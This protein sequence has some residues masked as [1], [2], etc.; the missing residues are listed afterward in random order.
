MPTVDAVA[1]ALFQYTLEKGTLPGAEAE[2]AAA[3]LEFNDELA[4]YRL[5]R[6]RAGTFLTAATSGVTGLLNDET[7]LAAFVK[8]NASAPAGN[9]A[10]PEPTKAEIEAAK[11]ELGTIE[12]YLASV[13]PALDA[14]VTQTDGLATVVGPPTGTAE[15][16][17]KRPETLER[18]AIRLV[19]KM[20]GRKV[21]PGKMVTSLLNEG[22]NVDAFD[23][24]ANQTAKE[25]GSL[26]LPV[27]TLREKLSG[28]KDPVITFAI[29]GSNL[30]GLRQIS[31]GLPSTVLEKMQPGE[32]SDPELATAVS[33]KS[34]IVRARV[35][36]TTAVSFRLT[37]DDPQPKKGTVPT[38]TVLYTPP[39]TVQYR[40][41][42]EVPSDGMLNPQPLPPLSG[43][44]P[45]AEEG[46]F[47][48]VPAL[49]TTERT[50]ERTTEGKSRA[51]MAARLETGPDLFPLPTE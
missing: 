6:D 23:P 5:S 27:K 20:E 30:Q 36:N 33:E 7:K 9:A 49:P 31:C 16:L 10:K 28:V 21:L 44:I 3:A 42:V 24:Y 39:I 4:L 46:S 13:K 34:I 50:T 47:A 51:K 12:A 38:W 1:P 35:H 41:S 17:G 48:T 29:L 43:F 26:L 11:T 2:I 40:G 37:F 8:K 18:A 14:I 45:A 32:T 25:L 22:I 15:A 19:Q